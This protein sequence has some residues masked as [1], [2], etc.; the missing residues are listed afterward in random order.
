[1]SK[2]FFSLILCLLAINTNSQLIYRS[3]NSFGMIAGSKESKFQVLTTHGF[4]YKGWYA[5]IGT[6]VDNYHRRTVPVVFSLLRDIWPKKTMFL[7][8]N[9]GAQF[10]WE[11]RPPASVNSLSYK[12][13]PGFFAEAGAGFRINLG[14]EGQGILFGTYYSY[15]SLT[16]KAV[17][18]RWCNNPPCS[19]LT[20]Y[21]NARLNRWAF[22]MGL[23]F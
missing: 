14:S 11:D 12:A 23:V 3:V 9:I 16:E 1:M 13:M 22:K 17:F 6:G 2:F 19:L 5:G 15:K 21:Y 7:Q 18:T 20:E 8:T 4:Q 10:L